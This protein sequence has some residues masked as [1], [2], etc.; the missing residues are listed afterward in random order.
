VLTSL[1][2][3]RSE[4]FDFSAATL[5]HPD[6]TGIARVTDPTPLADDWLDNGTADFEKKST[7]KA[8]LYSLLIPGL[9]QSYLGETQ[10]AKIFYVVEAAI[11]TSFVVFL[12]QE[13]LRED[14]YIQYAQTFAGLQSSDHSDDFYGI[15]TEHDTSKD[16]EDE[17][18]SEGRLEL[19]PYIDTATLDSYFMRERVSDYEPWTWRSAD[20]RRA[21]QDRRAASKTAER[22]ALYAV[23]A[24]VVNRVASAFFAYRSSVRSNSE[25]STPANPFSIDWDAGGFGNNGFQAG[26]SLVRT[27]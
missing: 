6:L 3:G 4:A 1:V 15:L 11:V 13:N 14:E 10:Q 5:D 26:V 17:I 12:V 23:A 16:Y 19:Y 2:A 25:R 24:A 27:F 8:V 20:H 22:R 9:G 7:S 18:K 21:Y